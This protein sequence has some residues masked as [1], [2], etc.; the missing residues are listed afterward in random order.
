MAQGPTSSV[1]HTK[2]H[3]SEAV[4]YLMRVA[5]DAG[6]SGIARKLQGVR[7]SIWRASPDN[8]LAHTD[9]PKPN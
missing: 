4:T 9:P 3:M 2:R 6:L 1:A 8:E 5:A 7:D